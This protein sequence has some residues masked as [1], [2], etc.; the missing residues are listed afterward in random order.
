MTTTYKDEFQENASSIA[1]IMVLTFLMISGN[2]YSILSLIYT[3]DAIENYSLLNKDI[4]M[5]VLDDTLKF[6]AGIFIITFIVLLGS[7][8]YG[9]RHILKCYISFVPSYYIYICLFIILFISANIFISDYPCKTRKFFNC[10]LVREETDIND[11]SIIQSTI[12]LAITDCVA[13]IMVII[14]SVM[15]DKVDYCKLIG[16]NL[17]V[18]LVN[19][20]LPLM[21]FIVLMCG[22]ILSGCESELNDLKQPKVFITNQTDKTKKTAN[23]EDAI[24]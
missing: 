5:D 15:L 12:I 7:H 9:Y 8:I 19:M 17:L 20:I 16:L 18:G 2:T 23:G 1:G 24:V 21:L 10:S 13:I 3:N 4:T 6:Y 14:S 22:Q 11:D